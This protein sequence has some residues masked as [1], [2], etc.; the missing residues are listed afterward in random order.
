MF[1]GA[2]PFHLSLDIFLGELYPGWA[3]IDHHS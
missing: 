2:P 3:A 1:T